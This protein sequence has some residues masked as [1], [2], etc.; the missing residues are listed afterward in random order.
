MDT[1][2]EDL[3]DRAEED[4]SVEAEFDLN[5]QK[6]GDFEAQL[7]VEPLPWVEMGDHNGRN[8]EI[9]FYEKDPKA[10]VYKEDEIFY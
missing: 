6:T 5:P 8:K 10:V 1:T 9:Q 4:S 2:E 7:E 3:E